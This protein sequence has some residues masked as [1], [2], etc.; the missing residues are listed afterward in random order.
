[1]TT[2][3]TSSVLAN[4]A[5]TAGNYGAAGV[6]TAITVDAQG[7]ITSAA[8][9]TA[10]V[11]NT[12]ITGLITGSQLNSTGV[13]AGNYGAAAVQTIITVDDQGRITSAANA[14]S[15][16]ANTNITGLI[17]SSQIAT[18]ANTQ[19]TGTIAPHQIQT[20]NNYQMGSFG[21]GTPA[22]G[23]A[24][25]IRATNNITAFYSSDK[26][27]KENI[28]DIDNAIEKVT[29][30]GGKYFDWTDEYLKQHGGEDDYFLRKN[31]FGVI[32]QDVQEVFPEAV[33]VRE[34]GVLAV[35]YE[36]MCA[37]AFA[38]IKELKHE[39]DEL[40]NQNNN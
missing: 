15:T 39:L 18:V 32:A 7:R 23:T 13:T 24:G 25:E 19:I 3:V 40:K 11:A 31:D 9:V 4:T 6:Q 34:N 17:T 20:A 8:N 14:T 10:T 33:R 37:L 38:A 16:V 5:V 29:H 26:K 27:L 35:D 28:R 22:S 36:K 30:I 2:K 1:M 21:V 12:N